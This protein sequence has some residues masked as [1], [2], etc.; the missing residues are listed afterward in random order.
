[1]DRPGKLLAGPL[2]GSICLQFRNAE[3]ES[4]SSNGDFVK[5]SWEGEG[6]EERQSQ[7]ARADLAMKRRVH[8]ALELDRSYLF[9]IV[10]V[11]RR[12][13]ISQQSEL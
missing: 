8:L 5:L 3:K 9:S 12:D 1:M 4:E 6:K 11:C 10:R 7:N 13:S 2:D